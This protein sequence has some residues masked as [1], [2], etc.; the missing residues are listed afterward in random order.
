M[1]EN[2]VVNRDNYSE[3]TNLISFLLKQRSEYV[4][5]LEQDMGIYGK[6]LLYLIMR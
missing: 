6:V 1:Y 5:T 2:L 4:A 3:I